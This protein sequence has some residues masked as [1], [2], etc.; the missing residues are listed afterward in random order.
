MNVLITGGLGVNGSWVT[1]KFVQRG[2]QPVVYERQLNTDLVGA[3]AERSTLVS[4]DINDIARLTQ[5]LLEHDIECI[6]HMAAMVVGTQTELLQAFR[7]N[8]LGTVQ[9]LEAARIAGVRRVVYTSSRAVAGDVT[10]AAAHPTYQPMDEDY[11]VAPAATYDACKVAGEVMGRNYASVH[12]LEFVALRFA[13]IIGPGKPARHGNNSVYSAMIEESLAG[14]PFDVPRGGDQL[15]D[16]IYVD[17]AAEGVVL[18]T[19]HERPSFDTYNISRGVGAN[20]HDLADAVRRTVPGSEITVGPGLDPFGMGRQY[21]GVMDNSRAHRDL[22]F[23]PR[24]DLD[25]MVENYARV[26]RELGLASVTIA[27]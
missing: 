3:E 15:D 25:D 19:L 2:F 26:T 12:G 7:V 8:A 10:G 16:L 13:A 18:A 27:P 22:G 21:Y 20:L 23:D 11:R 17:D 6:V 9:V 4:G 5:T 14:R 1:R 24:F